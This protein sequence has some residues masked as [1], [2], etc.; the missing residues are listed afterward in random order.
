MRSCIKVLLKLLWYEAGR[1]REPRTF[2]VAVFIM[3]ICSSRP[4]NFKIL[5]G[6]ENAVILLLNKSLS[7]YAMLNTSIDKIVLSLHEAWYKQ[8]T[9]NKPRKQEI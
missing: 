9:Q 3:L 1:G 6:G 2:Y 7:D 5:Y 8:V 4:I